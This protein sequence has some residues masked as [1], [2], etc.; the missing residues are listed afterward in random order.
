MHVLLDC[1]KYFDENKTTQS[2]KMWKTE[3]KVG[4]EVI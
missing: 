2:H 4:Y 3:R 1:V